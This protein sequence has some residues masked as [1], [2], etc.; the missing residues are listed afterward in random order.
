MLGEPLLEFFKSHKN[1]V[2]LR[3]IRFLH[4]IHG[5]PTAV[6]TSTCLFFL[7]YKSLKIDK[8]ITTDITLSSNE[9]SER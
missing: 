6:P 1:H 7:L 5:A 4:T 2:L 3:S 8:S 9:P